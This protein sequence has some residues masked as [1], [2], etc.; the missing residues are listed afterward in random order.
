MAD[1]TADTDLPLGKRL[2]AARRKQVKRLGK[3]LIRGLANFLGRQSIVGDEPILDTAKFPFLKP[4]V[5]NWETIRGEVREIL[6]H[7]EAVPLFQEVSI[8]QMRIAKGNN[9]RTFILF[10]FGDKLQKN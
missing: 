5:D 1:A 4:F 8:D 10:G 7:R 2:K 9:W 3:R 6:K